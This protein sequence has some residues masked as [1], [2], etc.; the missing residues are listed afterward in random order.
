MKIL[1][2]YT[3]NLHR[4][5]ASIHLLVKGTLQKK[6]LNFVQR[7]LKR[8]DLLGFPSLGMMKEWAVR[9]QEDFMLSLQL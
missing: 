8:L 2:G 7:T 4:L 9:V 6:P 5:K 1:K 3:K